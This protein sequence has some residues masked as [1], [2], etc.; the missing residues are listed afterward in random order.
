MPGK[1]QRSNTDG[2]Q[3]LTSWSGA[4]IESSHDGLNPAN[5]KDNDRNKEDKRGKKPNE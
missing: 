2:T 3:S 1:Q 5:L 4:E